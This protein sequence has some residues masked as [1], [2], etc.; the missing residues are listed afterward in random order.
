MPEIKHTF[1]VGRMNKDLDER[2][3]PNGEY[4]DA[5]NIEVSGSDGSNVGSV[6][7]IRG[8]RQLKNVGITGAKC[9][10]S[11]ADTENEK[12]Y[13][14]VCGTTVDAII[15]YDQVSDDIA[16]VCVDKNNVLNLSLIHI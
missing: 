8:N 6:Q 9:I 4:R 16:F 13:W 1:T 11:I 2:L 3:L 5:M 10:G 15:E 14:F 12:I 7:N